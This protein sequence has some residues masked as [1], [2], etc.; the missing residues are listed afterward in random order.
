MLIT[1]L[2]W[3]SLSP[4]YLQTTPRV[5]FLFTLERAGP[6]TIHKRQWAPILGYLTL[7]L[8]VFEQCSRKTGFQ[9]PRAGALTSACPRA[10]ERGLR[11]GSSPNKDCQPDS[12]GGALSGMVWPVPVP[13]G[14]GRGG[15][16]VTWGPWVPAR[17]CSQNYTKDGPSPWGF[18]L[19]LFFVVVF[20]SL[21]KLGT[22]VFTKCFALWT[23]L[24]RWGASYFRAGAWRCLNHSF[25]WK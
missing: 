2:V 6:S 22:Q 15:V 5:L 11:A 23:P 14:E 7:P 16:S 3:C 8:R 9:E 20:T 19:L 21:S 17:L 4:L 18:L 12:W 25:L 10:L 13:L 1:P 24:C